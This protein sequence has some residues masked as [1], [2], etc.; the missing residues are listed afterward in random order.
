MTWNKPPSHHWVHVSRYYVWLYN[1]FVQ[2]IAQT[3]GFVCPLH[4]WWCDGWKFFIPIK[5]F[6]YYFSISNQIFVCEVCAEVFELC[7][8][9]SI[10]NLCLFFFFS[11]ENLYFVKSMGYVWCFF[12]QS[13]FMRTLFY[14]SYHVRE[15]V[16]LVLWLLSCKRDCGPWER[17]SWPSKG[18]PSFMYSIRVLC[19]VKNNSKQ[20]LA[21]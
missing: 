5:S 3:R 11:F 2:I 15:I 18:N 12:H 8:N 21:N 17:W 10:E 19:L 1:Q 9:L 7:R 6:W 13:L 4:L 20:T 16:V 14:D